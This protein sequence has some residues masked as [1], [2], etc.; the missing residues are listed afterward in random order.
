[1]RDKG[2]FFL[3]FLL[4]EIY[5][6]FV[7]GCHCSLSSSLASALLVGGG[8][9]V[10]YHPGQLKVIRDAAQ[11][12]GHPMAFVT[13]GPRTRTRARRAGPAHLA[14]ALLHQKADVDPV[15][16]AH[17]LSLWLWTQVVLTRTHF[18]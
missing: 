15:G 14:W 17:A 10:V 6:L 16:T 5:L 7:H 18:R 11:G 13:F 1:M 2:S 3:S 9:K 4:G 8:G 12:P